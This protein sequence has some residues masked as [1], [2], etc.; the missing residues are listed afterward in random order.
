MIIN[1]KEA[2]LDD[3]AKNYQDVI[4]QA[5]ADSNY[6]DE[7]RDLFSECIGDDNLA[8]VLTYPDAFKAI[9]DNGFAAWH[10]FILDTE[11]N[12][13]KLIAAG[14]D[15][16][17]VLSVIADDIFYGSPYT[18]EASPHLI[19]VYSNDGDEGIKEIIRNN[20]TGI[21]ESYLDEIVSNI[22]DFCEEMLEVRSFLS[23]NN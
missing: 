7:L 4:R 8:T 13:D 5:K 2:T 14:Y 6:C 18:D 20:H 10:V 3:V 11:S 19:D 22:G 16:S 15:K 21:N 17:S 9:D 12:I 1:L 23:G